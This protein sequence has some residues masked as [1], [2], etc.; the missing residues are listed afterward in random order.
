[1]SKNTKNEK[2]QVVA[3]TANPPTKRYDDAFKQQAVEN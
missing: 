3:A 1:M 2:P